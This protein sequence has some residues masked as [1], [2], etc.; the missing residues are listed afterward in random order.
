MFSY[1]NLS[2]CIYII[3]NEIYRKKIQKDP[4]CFKFIVNMLLKLLKSRH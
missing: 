2:I 3:F 4:L 1:Y